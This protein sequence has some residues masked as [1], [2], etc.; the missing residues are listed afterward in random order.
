MGEIDGPL[1]GANLLRLVDAQFLGGVLA[2]RH[3]DEDRRK[4]MGMGKRE[5]EGEPEEPMLV[6][7]C[8]LSLRIRLRTP[9]SNKR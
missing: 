5:M 1:G 2:V 7:V 9:Y 4:G 3:V 6:E 8:L